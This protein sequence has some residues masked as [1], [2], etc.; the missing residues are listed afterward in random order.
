MKEN[1]RE[2]CLQ[3]GR[4]DEPFNYTLQMVEQGAISRE[5]SL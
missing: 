4:K 1:L 3:V 2:Y 5:L